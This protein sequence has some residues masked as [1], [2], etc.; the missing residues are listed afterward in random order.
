M[1]E[2]LCTGLVLIVACAQSADN[3]PGLQVI[4]PEVRKICDELSRFNSLSDLEQ[5][6]GKTESDKI[7]R[8]AN[9]HAAGETIE[10]HALEFREATAQAIEAPSGARAYAVSRLR[11]SANFSG[12]PSSRWNGLASQELRDQ[13]GNPDDERGEDAIYFCDPEAIDKIEFSV[14]GG[15]ISAIS[16]HPYVDYQTHSPQIQPLQR[17]EVGL[18]RRAPAAFLSSIFFSAARRCSVIR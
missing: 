10:T 18:R 8:V 2:C 14:D 4:D 13:I 5:V 7:E 1:R 6:L 12:L 11:V 9:P 16:W 15:E 3:S 17:L